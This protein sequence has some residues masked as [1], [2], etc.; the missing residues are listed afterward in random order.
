MRRYGPRLSLPRGA[1]SNSPPQ[2]WGEFATMTPRRSAWRAL[3]RNGVRKGREWAGMARNGP[4]WCRSF[5]RRL[6]GFTSGAG[7]DSSQVSHFAPFWAIASLGPARRV[8]S[9]RS[10]LVSFGL[11]LIVWQ[12]QKPVDGPG[13]GPPRMS[14]RG[15]GRTGYGQLSYEG[16]SWRSVR[17]GRGFP[18]QARERRE[19]RHVADCPTSALCYARRFLRAARFA[20]QCT[21]RG[22]IGAR[23]RS[24][25]L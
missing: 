10:H 3:S 8:S 20:R 14:V 9:K 16:R 23:R 25:Q 19:G 7:D 5:T 2:R 18:C 15:E 12:G 24:S 11:L 17:Q 1:L 22:S 4:E 21:Q 13:V 6:H